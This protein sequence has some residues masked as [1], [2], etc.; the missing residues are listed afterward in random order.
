MQNVPLF[1][2]VLV[3]LG[4]VPACGETSDELNTVG[5]KLGETWDAVKDHGV[6]KRHDFEAWSTKAFDGFDEKFAAAKKK[7]DE[8][9]GDAARALDAQW[10][11]AK[12]KLEALKGASAD[13]WEKAKGEFVE[14]MDA[15]EKSIDGGS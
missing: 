6:K 13:G 10:A 1:L 14:A 12:E 2:A 5:K 15:L 7:A 8:A 4:V 3:L 11:V 9:G